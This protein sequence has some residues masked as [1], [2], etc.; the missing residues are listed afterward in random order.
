MKGHGYETPRQSLETDSKAR[1]GVLYPSL[2][3][4]IRPASFSSLWFL[5]LGSHYPP[6]RGIVQLTNSATLRPACA[7]LRFRNWSFTN[8][9]IFVFLAV[10]FL[11][12]P[13]VD[14][15]N[16]IKI[17]KD[18]NIGEN[19]K[20][21][22]VLAA[23]GQITVG[24]LVENNVVTL[25]GSVVLTSTA[26]VRGNV[27]C[28]GG[29]VV[30]GNGAQVF[31]DITEVNSSNVFTAISSA[32]YDN[33][34]EWSWLVDIIY[35]CFFALLFSLALLMAFLFP[36]PLNAIVASIRENKV[37]SFFWGAI[38][39]LMIAPFFMLLILSFI[40]IPL[41][42]LAFSFI[43]LAFMFGFISVSALLGN[44]VL[45]NIFSHHKKSL[46]RETLLG[47]ILWWVIGWT[48]FYVGMIIKTVVI[49]IGFGGVLLALFNFG[50]NWR[51]PEGRKS[52]AADNHFE[53]AAV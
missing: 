17:G 38:G 3:R 30:R 48:P 31:G 16:I 22:Y 18:I 37:K 42:P 13:Q 15:K 28:I 21:D 52:P 24:G 53:S 20:A 36:R 9:I 19:Q 47:L 23:G 51:K 40:G 39:T 34:D 10:F 46:I 5:K 11:F 32:F 4:I 35:F 49:T 26:V 7:G 33:T 45:A 43:L 8:K 25:G 1:C 27:I 29:V 50:Y 44:F 2:C 12:V 6:L 14:A 41:I